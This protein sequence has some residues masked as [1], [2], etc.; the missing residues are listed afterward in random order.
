[1]IFYN[2]RLT[3]FLVG[4]SLCYSLF[5]SCL[6]SAAEGAGCTQLSGAL[7]ASIS[8]VPNDTGGRLSSNWSEAQLR[9]HCYGFDGYVSTNFSFQTIGVDSGQTI[10]DGGVSYRLYTTTESDVFYI[11]KIV[12]WDKEYP[13]GTEYNESIFL[14]PGS[15]AI[16]SRAVKIQ[17]YSTSSSMTPGI[18]TVGT[19]SLIRARVRSYTGSVMND[20]K[21]DLS[22]FSFEVKGPSCS[23]LMPTEVKLKSVNISTLRSP[24]DTALAGNFNL[25]LSCGGNTPA[26]KVSYSMSDV[27]DPTNLSTS[28]VAQDVP[29]KAT[30]LALQVLDDGVPVN[31]GALSLNAFGNIPRGGGGIGKSL[32]VQYIRTAAAGTPGV[33]K[34]AATVTLSY[35]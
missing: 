19:Q 23:L 15:G 25:V 20:T 30:G 22:A 3:R 1:M 33:M 7:T 17:F 6:S 35:R 10:V 24:G 12:G 32:S 5:F 9:I 13:F 27:N 34:A 4:C 21:M 8:P 26:Y 11:G 29:G 14:N 28:L 18:R 2:A 31:F 16:F